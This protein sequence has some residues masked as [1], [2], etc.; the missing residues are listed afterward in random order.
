[1]IAYVDQPQVVNT[2]VPPKPIF[3]KDVAEIEDY[4]AD[5]YALPTVGLLRA[6]SSFIGELVYIENI[7]GTDIIRIT[8][9]GID[10]CGKILPAQDSIISLSPCS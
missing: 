4:P 10:L 9:N 8:H 1:M 5:N 3:I 6:G 7:Y 2:T